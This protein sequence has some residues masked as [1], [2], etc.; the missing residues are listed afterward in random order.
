M[1]ASR[2]DDGAGT[3][4]KRFHSIVDLAVL[5]VGLSDNVLLTVWCFF[6]VGL[7]GGQTKL[8]FTAVP[9]LSSRKSDKMLYLPFSLNI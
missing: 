2:W 9:H 6:I 3:F 7:H 4:Q 1:E 8:A 5:N